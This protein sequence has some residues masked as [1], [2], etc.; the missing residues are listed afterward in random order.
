MR[1]SA[2][3][4]RTQSMHA[5]I[6]ELCCN[7]R[8]GYMKRFQHCFMFTVCLRLLCSTN[9]LLKTHTQLLHKLG[10]SKNSNTQHMLTKVFMPPSLNA[11]LE[12]Y[13]GK[14]EV[15]VVF[16]QVLLA[17]CGGFWRWLVVHFVVRLVL[18]Q[19]HIRIKLCS[20]FR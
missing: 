10:S 2:L 5:H 1:Q 3:P 8:A 9:N 11:E 16:L 13:S 19:W 18:F 14:F 6:S 15:S 12:S 4:H 7:L 17:R 20:F